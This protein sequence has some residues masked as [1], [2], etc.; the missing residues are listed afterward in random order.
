MATAVEKPKRKKAEKP[1]PPMYGMFELSVPADV[2]EAPSL[3]ATVESTIV[4]EEVREIE[5][6]HEVPIQQLEE[7][8]VIEEIEAP[9]SQLKDEWL[10]GQAT[11]VDDGQ[12]AMFENDPAWV[13]HWKGMPE[14]AQKDLSPVQSIA[15]HFRT[16]ADREA[17][18]KLVGQTI[19]GQTRSIWHPQADIGRMIDKRFI[20]EPSPQL[21]ADDEVPF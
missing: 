10:G 20:D 5:A 16:E 15:V 7:E 14:F 21:D 8:P 18:G 3:I 19:T 4:A 17:F 11:K 1:E 12:M 2:G 6:L 9:P 13:Q